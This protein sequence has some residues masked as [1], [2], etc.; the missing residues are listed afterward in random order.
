MPA[1]DQGISK[2]R[3][4][5]IPHVNITDQGRCSAVA[6]KAALIN[7]FGPDVI[8]VSVGMSKR[9]EDIL[10]ACQRATKRLA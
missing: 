6:Q 7:E 4:T 5:L 9:G 2:N 3:F 10:S 1:S 8:T